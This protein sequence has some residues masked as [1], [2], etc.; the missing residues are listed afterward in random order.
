METTGVDAGK[1]TA[2]DIQRYLDSRSVK[3]GVPS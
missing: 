1:A 3:T 2:A